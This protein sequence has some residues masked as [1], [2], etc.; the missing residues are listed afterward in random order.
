MGIPGLFLFLFILLLSF[1]YIFLIIYFNFSFF[2]ATSA[3]SERIFSSASDILTSDRAHLASETVQA[4]MCLKHWYH[5]GIIDYIN[6]IFHSILKYI[7]NM[8]LKYNKFI[9]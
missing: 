4:L 1:D 2:K 9:I 8:R 5:S 7:K 6:Y 3:P